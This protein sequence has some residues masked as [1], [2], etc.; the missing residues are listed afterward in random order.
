MLGDQKNGPAGIFS[1]VFL[2]FFFNF[3]FSFLMT[4]IC[5]GG[6]LGSDVVRVRCVRVF[7]G[8]NIEKRAG[9]VAV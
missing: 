4:K 9:V 1:L 3:D 6:G 5:G 8:L 7:R 2:F